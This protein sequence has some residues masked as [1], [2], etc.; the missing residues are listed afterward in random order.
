MERNDNITCLCGG[1]IHRRARCRACFNAAHAAQQAAR[2][3]KVGNKCRCGAV[4]YPGSKTCR[5]C[6]MAGVGAATHKAMPTIISPHSPVVYS[7]FRGPGGIMTEWLAS[8]CGVPVLRKW[9]A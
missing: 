3:A 5:A 4:I 6:N 2:R 1:E 8:D 9:R 7:G